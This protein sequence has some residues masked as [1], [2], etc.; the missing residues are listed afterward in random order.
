[1]L[2]AYQDVEDNL[3]A[4]RR[5]DEE[6]GTE[7]AA[8]LATGVAL[9]QARIRYDEGLVTYLEVATTEEAALQAQLSAIAIQGR[10]MTATVLLIKALGGGWDDSALKANNGAP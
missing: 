7:A 5:L 1:M 6:S 9:R 10:R 8:V 2:S 3:A 4:L